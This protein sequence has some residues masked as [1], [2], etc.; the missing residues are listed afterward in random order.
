M[1]EHVLTGT[2]AQE[3]FRLGMVEATH[4]QWHGEE[5][6]IYID[7]SAPIDEVYHSPNLEVM[8]IA[9]QSFHEGVSN[10]CMVLVDVTTRLAIGQQEFKVVRLIAWKLSTK[11]KASTKTYLKRMVTEFE[12]HKLVDHH[13]SIIAELGKGP[14]TAHIQE[15]MEMLDVQKSE[16]QCSCESRC[17]KIV[18]PF[19]PFSIPVRTVHKQQE[20]FVNLKQWHERKSRN[21]NIIQDAVKAG[22]TNPR[23]LTVEKCVAGIAA[24]KRQ[25]LDLEAKADQLQQEH[26][27]NRYKSAHTL[28]NPQCHKEI[29]EIIRRKEQKDSWSRIKWATGD[30]RTGAT[31]KVQKYVNGVKVDVLEALEMNKEIQEVTEKQFD[32]AHSAA[33]TRSS[34]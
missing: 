16:I 29:E 25:L 14:I 7:G 13:H 28:A 33:I 15:A 30:P 20:A 34:L 5:P 22:I 18:K 23:D 21:S 32:L 2:L 31:Q 8:V 19:L 11:N 12:R 24:C 27:G 4:T 9:Q 10:H 17:Q 3:F 6:H 1:N 26:L